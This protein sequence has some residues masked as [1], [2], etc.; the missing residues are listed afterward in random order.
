MGSKF[1]TVK[2]GGGVAIEKSFFDFAKDN[3]REAKNPPSD[4]SVIK[5]RYQYFKT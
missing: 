2:F 5:G 1:N 4:T 3:L